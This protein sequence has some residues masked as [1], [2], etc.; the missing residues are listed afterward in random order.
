MAHILHRTVKA[1]IAALN[2]KP[3]T[4]VLDFGCGE[5]PYREALGPDVN[6]IGA[7][8]A[9]NDLADVTIEDGVV[10]LP[11]QSVDLVLSTQ[12]LEHVTDPERYLNECHRILRPGGRLLLT[13]HGTMFYHPHP[14]DLWRWTRE[15]LVQI[16]R[17]ALFDVRSTSPLLGAVPVGLW[18]LMMNLQAHLPPGIRHACVS[19][20]TLLMS[21]S[22]RFE[23][24]AF[25]ADC[26]YVVNAERSQADRAIL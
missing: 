17:D 23:W 6:Y 24:S 13:T 8:L 5:R 22:D 16:M 2:L 12:V 4:R 26:V 10:D 9:G 20:F 1:N 14:T 7:D 15:G 18:L 25:R 3:G 21:L 19:F 11:D